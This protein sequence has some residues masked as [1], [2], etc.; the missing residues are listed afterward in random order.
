M[1]DSPSLTS[2]LNLRSQ[3]LSGKVREIYSF[4]SLNYEVGDDV[5]HVLSSA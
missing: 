5:S 3:G 1:G 4:I 2:A